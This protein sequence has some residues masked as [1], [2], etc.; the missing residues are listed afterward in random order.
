MPTILHPTDFSPCAEEARALATRLA[1]ALDAELILLHVAVE[2]PLFREGLNRSGDLVRF[3]EEQQAWAREALEERA[4]EARGQG[5]PTLVRV[6]T[7]VPHEAI[8][9]TARQTGAALIVM[10][11][12]GRGPL[13]RFLLG[14]VA[15][16][17]VRTAPCP[18][19]T[20]RGS[21]E[22]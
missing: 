18:V 8:V 14:S 10:G 20:Q 7:G 22:P 3:F 5:V 1:R 6:V 19:V 16:R 2:T 9:E 11:T 13:T 12:Q 17:V 4:A 21:A 15:D